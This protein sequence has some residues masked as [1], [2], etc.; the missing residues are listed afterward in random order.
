MSEDLI[1]EGMKIFTRAEFT[2]DTMRHL[3]SALQ[4]MREG[5]IEIHKSAP[6]HYMGTHQEEW[7][8]GFR[9]AIEIASCIVLGELPRYQI[10]FQEEGE[11]GP[12]GLTK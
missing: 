11:D 6:D 4:T 1:G 2:V 3:Q 10:K 5:H 12:K 9:S 7:L 8:D